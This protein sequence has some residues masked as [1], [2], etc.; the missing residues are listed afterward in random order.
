MCACQAVGFSSC[1]REIGVELAAG[2]MRDSMGWLSVY[3]G[4]GPRMAAAG[5]R[6]EWRRRHGAP[7]ITVRS[8]T[9]R[10]AQLGFGGRRGRGKTRQPRKRNEHKI[11]SKIEAQKKN[12]HSTPNCTGMLP[13][14]SCYGV[15]RV[16]QQTRKGRRPN[17]NHPK[18]QCFPSGE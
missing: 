6:A 2:A 16:A 1:Q 12:E 8:C 3:S 4:M 18:G 11:V 7:Q 13:E 10:L 14:W 17:P 9:P 15:T 5:G